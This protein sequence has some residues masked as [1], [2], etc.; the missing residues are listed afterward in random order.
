MIRFESYQILEEQ[1]IKVRLLLN[2]NI[3]KVE[4]PKAKNKDPHLNFYVNFR[5]NKINVL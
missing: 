2:H 1:K 5:T 3:L 4:C